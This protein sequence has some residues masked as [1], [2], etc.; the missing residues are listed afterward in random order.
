[1]SGM[2]ATSPLACL[3]AHVSGFSSVVFPLR[4]VAHAFGVA[5]TWFCR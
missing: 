3:K 4:G 2:V 5:P 1:V